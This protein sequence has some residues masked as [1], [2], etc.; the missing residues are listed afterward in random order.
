MPECIVC[1]GYY[2][3]NSDDGD[4]DLSCNRCGVDNR[5]WEEQRSKVMEQGG[6]DG[7][8]AFTGLSSHTPLIIAYLSFAFGWIGIGSLWSEI[9]LEIGLSTT[10]VT[11]IVALFMVQSIYERRHSLRENDL[12]MQCKGTGRGRALKIQVSTQLKAL[13]IPAVIAG[14]VLLLAYAL[15]QSNMVWSLSKWVFFEDR[16]KPEAKP[17]EDRPEEEP[18]PL[19][20]LKERIKNA[21]PLVFMSTYVGLSLGLVYYFSMRAARQYASRMN[22]QLP[23]PIFLQGDLL[24]R[25]VQR[26]AERAM[27]RPI[28]PQVIGDNLEPRSWIWDEMKRTDD[29][30]IELKA[31]VERE[32]QDESTI[33][34]W[35]ESVAYIIEAD[36]WSRIS[37]IKQAK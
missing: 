15:V 11:A 23:P 4:D 24:E 27:R 14:L 22:Q 7:L 10:I 3:G 26:E 12:L 2:E 16:D 34:N 30:G 18:D 20:A 31:I 17:E 35:T 37:S 6:I 1:K 25:V 36:P 28:T 19:N 13:L 32:Y 5:A 21:S 8:L 33:G 9:K 29:G